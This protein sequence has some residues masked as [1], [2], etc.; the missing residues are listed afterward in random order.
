LSFT[1][2]TS[3]VLST[4]MES[5][6]LESNLQPLLRIAQVPPLLTNLTPSS[7]TDR[8]AV[9]VFLVATLGY[10]TRG[11]YWDTPD[12]YYHVYFERPQ[13]AHNNSNANVDATR[14]IAQ[15]LEEGNYQC[16][17]FWGSQSGTSERFAEELGRECATRFSINALVADLSDYDASSI[18]S[19]QN[20]HFAIFLLSTYGEGDPSDNASDLWDWIKLV[21]ANSIALDT[22]RYT[23]FGLGNSNYKHYNRVLDIVADALDAAGAHAMIPRQKADDADGATEEDFR[24]WKDDVFAM[25][26]RMGHDQKSIAYHPSITIKFSEEIMKT[27]DTTVS[28][29]HQQSSINSAITLLVVKSARELF[30]AGDRNCVHMELDL[31]STQLGY[32]TGDHIAIWPCNPTEE[33]EQL[34]KILGLQSRLTESFTVDS[35]AQ[36][37]KPKISSP[38]TLDAAFRRQLQICGPVARKTVLEL[39]QFAPTP[40]AKATLLKLGQNRDRYEQLIA[41]THITLARLLQLASPTER[42]SDLPLAFVMEALLPL[43]P[44]YYSI[45]SSSVISPR[46]IALTALVVNKQLTGSSSETIYGLTSNYLLS[47]ANQMSATTAQAQTYR[48]IEGAGS[49][50][51][52]QVFAHIRKSKFKLPITSSTPLVLISAGTGFAPFRAFLQE[53]AKLHTIGKPVGNMLLFFGC[54]NHDDF[55][56][57]EETEKIQA[58]LDDKL[59][60][61]TAFSRHSTSPKMYVQDRVQEHA[62]KVLGMLEAGANM[63]ICGKASMAREVDIKIEA[64]VR[65][66]KQISDTEVKAWVDNLKKRGKWKADVWG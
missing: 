12:P 54:R 24:S 47:M 30:V 38:T 52:N 49:I 23:A 25:F 16:V 65:S 44:R 64:A 31:G 33:V 53:R 50:Q 22:L 51:G 48:R 29:M 6:S 7:V 26:R 62:I 42:W 40:E 60:I 8:L 14:N 46:R 36:S 21:K 13:V 39:A 37:V 15:R 45:S 55:I 5:F 9:L 59:E 35:P 10:V 3:P 28:S 32:K 61:I 63:Y 17:I 58:Q 2:D 1:I 11:R 34:A 41:S 66:M 4:A 19:I 20:T 56:Y 18:A 43:Q 27:S 57:H